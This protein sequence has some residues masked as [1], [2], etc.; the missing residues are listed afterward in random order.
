[1]ATQAQNLGPGKDI[2]AHLRHAKADTNEYVQVLP[3][4]VQEMM[5]RLP[6]VG[7]GNAAKTGSGDLQ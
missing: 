5:F 1:M 6:H 2:Q 7:E 3:E 4:S